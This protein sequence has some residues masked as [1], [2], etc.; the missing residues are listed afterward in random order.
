ML[1]S[2]GKIYKLKMKYIK[3]APSVA[4]MIIN[5]G[6]ALELP[7]YK[8]ILGLLKTDPEKFE[9][10]IVQKPHKDGKSFLMLHVTPRRAS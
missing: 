4:Q 10:S 6:W 2:Q 8:V 3:C 5:Q 1:T 7:Q 9:T